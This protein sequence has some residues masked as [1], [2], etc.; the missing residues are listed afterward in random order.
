MPQKLKNAAPGARMINAVFG[1]RIVSVTLQPGEV[2]DDLEISNPDDPVFKAMVEDGEIEMD[3]QDEPPV[4]RAMTTNVDDPAG[5][6]AVRRAGLDEERL[7][8]P[9]QFASDG[10]PQQVPTVDGTGGAMTPSQEEVGK[11]KEP[12]MG[13]AARK[14]EQTPEQQQ[15]LKGQPPKESKEKEVAEKRPAVRSKE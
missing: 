2:R 5:P 13:A 1:E 15:Q 12:P 6:D 4:V 10:G 8:P 14:V 11:R 7:T 9:S 3:P